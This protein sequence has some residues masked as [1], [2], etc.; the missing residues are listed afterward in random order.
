MPG[1]TIPAARAQASIST[2]QLS[3]LLGYIF[4]LPQIEESYNTHPCNMYDNIPPPG[5][6][7]HP[8]VVISA[9]P[10]E[11]KVVILIVSPLPPIT[12]FTI[13]FTNSKSR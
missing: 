3:D 13:I 12:L 7:N 5:C 2:T 11:G 1:V 10:H 9:R 4:W 6:Y 8:V